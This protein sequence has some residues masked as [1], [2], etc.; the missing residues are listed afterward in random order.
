MFYGRFHQHGSRPMRIRLT[1]IAAAFALAGAALS[2]AALA[3][4]ERTARAVVAEARG[5]IEAN[6]KAGVAGEAADVQTRARAALERAEAAIR[7]DNEDRAL[8]AAGAAAG[9]AGLAPAPAEP[10]GNGS[11]GGR[12]RGG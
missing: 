5:M 7:D 10:R 1:A 4:S 11:A 2:G 12:G 6:D 9:M 8:H 3:Q